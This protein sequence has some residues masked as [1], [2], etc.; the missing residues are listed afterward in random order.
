MSLGNSNL[1]GSLPGRRVSDAE[2]EHRERRA[3]IV[4]RCYALEED[5]AERVAR[6]RQEEIEE[7]GDVR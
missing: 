5:L 7:V 1:T 6:A 3:L 4:Q 2:R